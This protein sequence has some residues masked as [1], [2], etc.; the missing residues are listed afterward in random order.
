MKALLDAKRYAEVLALEPKT[1]G[2]PKELITEAGQYIVKAEKEE[3]GAKLS[4]N[5]CKE[6]LS[7]L[8]KN[9]IT[10]LASEEPKL[11]GCYMAASEYAKALALSQKHL[12]DKDLA[13]KLPWLYRFETAAVKLGKTKEAYQATKDV[14]TLSKIYKRNEFDDIAFDGVTLAMTYKDPNLLNESMAIIESK[15]PKDPRTITAYK[16]A[17]RFAIAR[18]DMLSNLKYSEK[19]YSL[20]NRLKVYVE[21]PWIEFNYAGLLAKQGDHKKA[22]AILSTLLAKKLSDSDRARALFEISSN[23]TAAGEKAKAKSSL[24]ECIKVKA[25]SPW[26]KLC[27]ESLDIL[28]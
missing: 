3:F 14:I 13:A 8:A 17:I 21:S 26:K 11:F 19:L 7:L 5:E 16:D 6:A 15:Y 28:K 20:Q 4:K 10:P 1:A 23:Y 9:R 22:I 24:Q 18:N 12:A 27:K 25:D 2:L